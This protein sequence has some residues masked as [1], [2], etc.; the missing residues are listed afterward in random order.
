MID[1]VR[2]LLSGGRVAHDHMADH[3]TAELA[4]AASLRQE[5]RRHVAFIEEHV[6]EVSARVRADAIAGDDRVR[7]R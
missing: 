6:A 3:S 7:G 1:W 5:N 2:R 4:E